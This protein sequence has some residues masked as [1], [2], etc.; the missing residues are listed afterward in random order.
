MN[1]IIPTAGLVLGLLVSL[2]LIIFAKKNQN[3]NWLLGT[4]LFFLWYGLVTT[5]IYRSGLI[6]EYPAFSR[7]GNIFSYL[8][9]P[10]LYFFIRQIIDRGIDWKRWYWWS[11]F[12]VIFYMVDFLPYFLLPNS[13][14]IM[15]IK[16]QQM[17]VSNFSF[18]EGWITPDYFQ[19]HFRQI[20]SFVFLILVYQMFYSRRKLILPLNNKINFKLFS[21]IF[22]LTCLY[23]VSIIPGY[24]KN[25]IPMNWYN[26]TYQSL[27]LSTTL[28][29]TAIFLIFNPGFLYG[30]YWDKEP[31]INVDNSIKKSQKEPEIN[32]SDLSICKAIGSFLEMK[33][34][35][36]NPAYSI[37]DLSREIEIPVYKLSPAINSVHGVNFNVWLNTFRIR[38]FERLAEIESYQQMGMDLLAEKCG[39][40]NRAT[41]TNACKKI[42][43]MTPGA[44]LK[45]KINTRVS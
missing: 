10:F 9:A 42:K 27:T 12:P 21:F 5:E 28:I 22:V 16:D 2:V 19:Y 17:G 34:V 33:K 24:I 15:L 31:Q 6:L 8:I 20:W 11:V 40:T 18:S 32:S 25:F 4:S 45:E 14:K 30:F 38:E 3:G 23:S 13:E 44:Y 35:F 41:F 39:F 43:G 7:T 37:H 26:L 36:L 29:S 1:Q